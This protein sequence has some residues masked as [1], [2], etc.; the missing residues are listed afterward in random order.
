MDMLKL[1]R[2][3]PLMEMRKETRVIAFFSFSNKAMAITV[4]NT[5]S[6]QTLASLYV[7]PRFE[8]CFQHVRL[9]RILITFLFHAEGD[10]SAF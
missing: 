6:N 9:L 5:W 2:T 3:Y 10:L 8:S 7:G 4:E 1:I